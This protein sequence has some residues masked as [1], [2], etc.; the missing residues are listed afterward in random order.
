MKATVWLF[1][2]PLVEVD[3]DWGSS[4]LAPREVE[5]AGPVEPVDEGPSL[6]RGSAGQ[7]VS[8]PHWTPE[9]ATTTFGFYT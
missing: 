5:P 7:V 2:L 6:Q 8:E 9:P 3:V 1:G 4:T